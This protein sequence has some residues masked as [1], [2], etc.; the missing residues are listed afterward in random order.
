MPK[1]AITT[2]SSVA[3][4]PSST[5]KDHGLYAPQLTAAQIAAIPANTLV[6]GAIVYDTDDN[7]LKTRVNG[8]V[9]QINTGP[10][11]GDVVGPGGAVDNNIAT[12]NGATSTLILS[13]TT[14]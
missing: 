12:F 2:F 9:Q 13:V 3:V 7:R 4:K 5:N 8:I 6:N 10:N 14:T 11:V 1:P